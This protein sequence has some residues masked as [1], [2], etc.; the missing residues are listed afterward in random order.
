MTAVPLIVRKD[1]IRTL[2]SNIALKA[3]TITKLKVKITKLK[4]HFNWYKKR[5]LTHL[6]LVIRTASATFYLDITI[7]P[8]QLLLL[9]YHKNTPICKFKILQQT[10]LMSN[11]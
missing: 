3:L 10:H 1:S 7:V 11:N 4:L 9:C 5:T 6:S 2:Q 8:L